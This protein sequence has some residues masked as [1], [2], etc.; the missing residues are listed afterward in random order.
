MSNHVAAGRRPDEVKSRRVGRRRASINRGARR[1]LF[2]LLALAGFASAGAPGAAAQTISAQAYA[3]TRQLAQP[4]EACNYHIVVA[5]ASGELEDTDKTHAQALS[6]VLIPTRPAPGQKNYVFSVYGFGDERFRDDDGGDYQLKPSG[7]SSNNLVNFFKAAGCQLP[8]TEAEGMSAILGG[9]AFPTVE[10]LAG[11]INPAVSETP[12]LTRLIASAVP[13]PEPRL[14]SQDRFGRFVRDFSLKIGWRPPGEV[15][16]PPQTG[17]E[18]RDRE[19]L[20]GFWQAQSAYW[21]GVADAK[22]S[23]VRWWSPGVLAALLALAGLL[24]LAY[25]G[26]RLL[27]RSS[28]SESEPTPA[29]TLSPDEAQALYKILDFYDPSIIRG[30]S[31]PS[32][33]VADLCLRLNNSIKHFGKERR[34]VGLKELK[35]I[36]RSFDSDYGQAKKQPEQFTSVYERLWGALRDYLT[37]HQPP[38]L[39][40][41]GGAA[42]AG[43]ILVAPG[44]LGEARAEIKTLL[45]AD[46]EPEGE[47]PTPDPPLTAYELDARLPALAAKVAELLSD[48]EE[49]IDELCRLWADA[50]ER[51]SEGSLDQVIQKSKA[52]VS[53]IEL[54]RARF[55]EHDLSVEALGV[56]VKSLFNTLEQLGKDSLKNSESGE[57]TPDT[58]LEEIAA[59][60]EGVIANEALLETYRKGEKETAE[61]LG[62]LLGPSDTVFYAAQR[63]AEDLTK[64]FKLLDAYRTPNSISLTD[65]LQKLHAEVQNLQTEIVAIENTIKPAAPEAAG[66]PHEMVQYMVQELDAARKGAT[67]KEA[68]AQREAERA[69]G[70]DKERL[71]L[72][73]LMDS[74]QP[75][76]NQ[77]AEL[78]G[79]VLRRL[80][81]NADKPVYGV[82][83]VA[84]LL[85]HLR[86]ES[87]SSWRLRRGLSAARD[88]LG[89]AT[90]EGRRADV[91]EVLKLEG[92]T[93]GLGRLLELLE[94]FSGEDIWKKGIDSGFSTNWMHDLLRANHLLQAYFPDG[95]LYL[96]RGAVTQACAALEVIMRDHGVQI[97]PVSIF[98]KPFD[99]MER[100]NPDAALLAMPEVK[101]RVKAE[102]YAKDGSDGFVVDVKLSRVLVGDEVRERGRVAVMIR[103]DWGV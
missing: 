15:L 87:P 4:G 37:K 6:L 90:A 44:A 99:G 11:F 93:Q 70:L 34:P 68:D 32:G 10:A 42:D 20:I 17:D 31:L 65:P 19:Q 81:Y 28:E 100:V 21:R 29:A 5:S 84:A 103:S 64:A 49:Q 95:E 66:T 102:Y 79:E 13:P 77:S 69:E 76:R 85:G 23:G 25:L 54:L 51:A 22:G 97:A 67:Q 30:Q 7:V 39:G 36:L 43:A 80:N 50:G 38:G 56:K 33:A 94:D 83:P 63:M 62:I 45:V 8:T 91:T 71:R 41:G 57:G 75:E 74:T 2:A 24:G 3:T 40:A 92:I 12:A 73:E 14:D 60:L 86:D 26:R 46:E 55:R 61:K 101:A 52:A 98:G 16:L 27:R 59:R 47:T 58:I 72:I 48:Y 88:A 35:S 53:I 96:M 9:E 18:G 1:A 82:E 78:V 89:E